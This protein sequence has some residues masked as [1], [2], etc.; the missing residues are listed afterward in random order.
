MG[1]KAKAKTAAPTSASVVPPPNSWRVSR[2]L[3][4]AEAETG[5]IPVKQI[6]VRKKYNFSHLFTHQLLYRPK[7]PC[8]SQSVWIL[9]ILSRMLRISSTI[10]GQTTF[11]LESRPLL[12][13]AQAQLQAL[14]AALGLQLQLQ[15]WLCR[16]RSASVPLRHRLPLSKLRRRHAT[17]T[18]ARTMTMM[19]MSRWENR[20]SSTLWSMPKVVVLLASLVAARSKTK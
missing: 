18:T 1:A 7:L 19:R 15:L 5:T 8:C 6:Q 12:P 16:S 14:G 13:A 20:Q 10:T 9:A 11:L 17:E 3:E 2:I 4:L